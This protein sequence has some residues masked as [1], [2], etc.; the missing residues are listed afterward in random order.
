MNEIIRPFATKRGGINNFMIEFDGRRY[1]AFMDADF[2]TES[3][4]A[5]L[6]AD[7][8]KYEAKVSIRVLASILGDGTNADKPKVTVRESAV[9]VA[10]PRE[11]VMLGDDPELSH[12][13][14]YR[15]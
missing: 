15:S 14:K 11:R 10:T 9:Q 2:S 3:N 6:G 7:E 8:R 12:G 13:G 1:E 4:V 5:E